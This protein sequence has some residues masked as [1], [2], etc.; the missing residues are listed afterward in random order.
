[1]SNHSPLVTVVVL[2][3]QKFDR[4]KRNLESIAKQEYRNIEVIIQDD[5]SPNFD[6]AY[7]DELCKSVLGDRTWMVHQNETNV[8]TVKSFNAAV[9][10]ANGEF[11]VPLSQ[12]DCFYR[13]DIVTKIVEFFQDHPDCMSCTAKRIGEKSKKVYPD[14]TDMDLLTVWDRKEL[15]NRIV[16]ENFISGSTMYYRTGFMKQRNGFRTDFLLLE[17][18]PFA[19]DMILEN[20]RIGFLDEITIVYGEDGVSSTMAQS[21]KMLA[22]RMVFYEKYI[23]PNT[24]LVLYKRLQQYITYL[25][26]DIRYRQKPIRR[27]LHNVWSWKVVVRHLYGMYIKRLEVGERYH[28]WTK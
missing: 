8:G 5:G 28:L 22:D 13:E 21:P 15:W 2:T 11:V 10:M 16:F 27:I 9:F 4:I 18:Y 6:R 19:A 7:V 20:Q 25:Y 12:D 14:R 3:Y 23:V 24:E 1:M 17:D 26:G